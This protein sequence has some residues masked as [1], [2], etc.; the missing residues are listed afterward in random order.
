M[1]PHTAPKIRKQSKRQKTHAVAQARRYSKII[2]QFLKMDSAPKKIVVMC[3][4]WAQHLA[5]SLLD[6]R[7]NGNPVMIGVI[8][9]DF[10]I[11]DSKFKSCFKKASNLWPKNVTVWSIWSVKFFRWYFSKI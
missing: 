7:P 5:K 3:T 4:T 11:E 6:Q 1:K 2:K 8:Q 10:A 9:E